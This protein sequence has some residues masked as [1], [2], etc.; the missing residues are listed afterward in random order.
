MKLFYPRLYTFYTEIQHFSRLLKLRKQLWKQNLTFVGAICTV[1]K[2]RRNFIIPERR[3]PTRAC[4][5]ENSRNNNGIEVNVYSCT[6]IATCTAYPKLTHT[7]IYSQSTCTNSGLHRRA[8]A[9]IASCRGSYFPRIA[10]TSQERIRSTGF[11]AHIHVQILLHTYTY[12]FTF[13][14]CIENPAVVAKLAAGVASSPSSTWKLRA[15]SFAR[16]ESERAS[17]SDGAGG[18]G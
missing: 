2:K 14:N 11:Y 8:R 7:Y 4:I 9:G 5:Y 3:S 1:T 17:R 6:H 16:E 12:T 15:A 18:G 13:A 10:S